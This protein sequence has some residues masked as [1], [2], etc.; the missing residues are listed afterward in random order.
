MIEYCELREAAKLASPGPWTLKVQELPAP[1]AHQSINTPGGSTYLTYHAVLDSEGETITDDAG[2]YPVPAKEDDLAYIALANPSV[3]LT[4]IERCHSAE[5]KLRTMR[6][7]Q[8]IT[9]EYD[10]SPSMVES[11][12]RQKLIELGWTPPQVPLAT[13]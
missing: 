11:A 12:L 7:G 2:Y 4:L 9:V 6:A 13:E 3:V 5:Q 10:L 1:P 8:T